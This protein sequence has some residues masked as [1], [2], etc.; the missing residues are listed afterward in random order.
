MLTAGSFAIHNDIGE[1]VTTI[2]TDG[3]LSGDSTTTI[4]TESAVKAYVDTASASV[5][6]P[7]LLES[8]VSPYQ[9]QISSTLG[10]DDVQIG[11]DG[12]GNFNV[13]TIGTAPQEVVT[14][15]KINVS[16]ATDSTSTST[17]AV[18]IDG[19]LGVLKNI[20]SDTMYLYSTTESSSPTT[21]ALIIDGGMSVAK[22]ITGWD[23]RLKDTTESTSSP[24]GALIVDGGISV[25]KRIT[26]WNVKML[27]TTDSTSTGTGSVLL[28]GGL[29]VAKN[30]SSDTM[31]L[32]SATNST[33]KTTG[34]LIV[35][36]GIGCSNKITADDMW[37]AAN[38]ESTAQNNGTLVV[39]GGIG[40]SKRITGE[41]MRLADGTD[42][43]STGTG[44]LITLGGVGVA[45]N[46]STDTMKVY[47][48]T[49]STNQ[50][51]GALVVN[52][53][54][55]LAKRLFGETAVFLGTTTP[56]IAIMP[57][58]IGSLL[59]FSSSGTTG[60]IASSN[61]LSITSSGTVTIKKSILLDNNTYHTEFS[62]DG[63]GRLEIGDGTSNN[64]SLTTL[65]PFIVDM[66]SYTTSLTNTAT[67]NFEIGNGTSTG[68]VV[69]NPLFI[70]YGGNTSRIYNNGGYMYL[71]SGDVTRVVVNQP[72]YYGAMP[73]TYQLDSSAS[74]NYTGCNT[75]PTNVAF[76]KIG[77]QV[78]MSSTG[79]PTSSTIANG[80]LSLASGT[81]PSGY[82][83][84]NTYFSFVHGSYTTTRQAFLCEIQS[85]GGVTIS[86]RNGTVFASGNEITLYDWNLSWI[87]A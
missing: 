16:D 73:I 72:P 78:T 80:G 71:G 43:T 21:G 7:L 64:T 48:T 55:G 63:A 33:S 51:S 17:G 85:G 13:Q 45:K 68:V 32:Y 54:M 9:L 53:G 12:T 30:I 23:M 81:I 44:S 3:T 28:E 22:R 4:P 59:E 5:P 79:F 67:G 56:Q 58:G 62:H 34:S 36:G 10:T 65:K 24:T 52:G 25:A 83:P 77:S 69:K 20:S 1:V 60:T 74:T 50:T 75:K 35:D 76:V 38:T 15:M 18:T 46:I 11:C 84:V 26:G 70:D 31:R 14:N 49:D 27:D 66:N 29:G 57:F 19:G 39:V 37:L 61:A 82:R 86:Q 2:S 47:S 8:A 42:S 6:V 87:T 40:V 41:N